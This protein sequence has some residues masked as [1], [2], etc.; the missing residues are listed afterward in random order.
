MVDVSEDGVEIRVTVCRGVDGVV[1]EA[2]EGVEIFLRLRFSRTEV[3]YSLKRLM[4]L[5]KPLGCL[6]MWAGGSAAGSGAEGDDFPQ[7][8]Q[9][10]LDIGFS[11]ESRLAILVQS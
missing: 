8:G 3:L 2:V 4:S 7:A 9:L 10:L 6:S 5:V 1:Y 11:L